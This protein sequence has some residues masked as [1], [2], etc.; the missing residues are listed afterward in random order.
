MPLSCLW[1]NC[2]PADGYIV[3]IPYLWIDRL[4]RAELS[5]RSLHVKSFRMSLTGASWWMCMCT[6]LRK[7]WGNLRCSAANRAVF[8]LKWLAFAPRTVDYSSKDGHHMLCSSHFCLLSQ[9]PLSLAMFTTHLW[10]P[11]GWPPWNV[12]LGLQRV[13][14]LWLRYVFAALQCLLWPILIKALIP[15]F[16][17]SRPCTKWSLH[18][19][20]GTGGGWTRWA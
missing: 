15:H 2:I 18:Y 17:D 20:F 6:L 16:S 13:P 4:V 12:A 8:T 1:N 10:L 3:Q 7:L 11:E 19:V 5:Q 14:H 9:L